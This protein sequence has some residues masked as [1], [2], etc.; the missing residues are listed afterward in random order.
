MIRQ[1]SVTCRSQQ[2]RYHQ[3]QEGEDVHKHCQQVA[4]SAL[5][6]IGLTPAHAQDTIDA[7]AVCAGTP[8]IEDNG[9]LAWSDNPF[10]S[11]AAPYDVQCARAAFRSD[12]KNVI[13]QAAS[14]TDAVNLFDETTF[15]FVYYADLKIKLDDKGVLTADPIRGLTMDR[16]NDGAFRT[17]ITVTPRGGPPHLL[18]K[19]GIIKPFTLTDQTVTVAIQQPDAPPAWPTVVL[20]PR[21]NT[22]TATPAENH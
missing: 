15:F 6:L 1:K 18:L 22:I 20:N 11:A 2:G 21:T 5:F 4:I 17:V 14:L 19:D 7:G 13:V 9:T 10:D 12:G 8:H 3:G 16:L